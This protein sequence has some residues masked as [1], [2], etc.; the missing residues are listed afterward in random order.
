MKDP[1]SAE[2]L[3][4]PPAVPRGMPSTYA[5]R[6]FG[7]DVLN[8]LDPETAS[9]VTDR[10]LYDI[11]LHGPDVLFYYDV[12]HPG[13]VRERG[14][15]LHDLTGAEVLFPS[16]RQVKGLDPEMVRSY[17]MGFLCHYVLDSECHPYIHTV[18]GRGI[19]HTRIEGDLDR[20][21]LTE[22]GLDPRYE[23]L[24]SHIFPSKRYADVLAAVMGVTSEEALQALYDMVSN[25]ELLVT[26]PIRRAFVK[27][28]IRKH[29]AYD[30][31]GGMLLTRKPDPEC[32]E[33][34]A[35]L[36]EMY[37]D[38]VRKAAGLMPLLIKRSEDPASPVEG[39]GRTFSGHS[40]SCSNNSL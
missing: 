16:R 11:G 9:L 1:V 35:K 13:P 26:G 4:I 34:T 23:M 38:C 39:F 7:A 18:E 14:M 36:R 21:L 33:S 17:L 27:H 19:T 15:T 20:Q 24:A 31:I 28:T 2:G 5:H 32:T 25:N 30:L 12:M 29:G 22:D 10:R 40:D 3:Y 37:D 8:A 6:R